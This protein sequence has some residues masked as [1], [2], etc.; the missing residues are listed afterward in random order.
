MSPSTKRNIVYFPDISYTSQRLS[1]NCFL[2]A[3]VSCHRKMEKS[4]KIVI[5]GAGVFGLTTARQLALEGFTN[6]T[7]LDRHMVPVR[8]SSVY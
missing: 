7:V 5:V 6:I 2:C 4:S 3:R 8:I 1:P